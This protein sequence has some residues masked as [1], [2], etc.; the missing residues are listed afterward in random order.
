MH[1]VS[2][3]VPGM[4]SRRT[5]MK[6]TAAA[7]ALAPLGVGTASAADP[8]T[9]TAVREL[10]H[11]IPNGKVTDGTDTAS[12]YSIGGLVVRGSDAYFNKFNDYGWT[13]FHHIAGFHTPEPVFTVRT[14]RLKGDVETSPADLG[15]VNGLSYF[16]TE[17][18]DPD[19]V[20]SFY[21]P[22]LKAIGD[23]QV[24]QVNLNGEVTALFKAR[25]GSSHKKIA[26]VTYRGNGTWIVGTAGETKEEA[27]RFLRPYY[28]AKIVGDIFELDDFFQVPTV[29]T[30]NLGQDIYYH[31]PDDELLIP[32]WD[33]KSQGEPPTGLKNRIVVAE[34]GTITDGRIYSPKRWID[35][36]VPASAASKFE[37]EG[38]TR[39]SDGALFVASNIKAPD[40]REIDGI[41]KL[42]GK[43]S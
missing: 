6:S 5:V 7:L 31:A 27:D 4:M 22:M 16:A 14:V 21:I 26:S 11:R 17:G 19:E 10:I 33:G 43:K 41:H 30:Y 24:A 42:T 34:L 35:L 12:T 20:G 29:K 37:F 40:G 1:D 38:V 28:T 9:T 3:G 18:A 36:S 39:G 2:S 32:L 25:R 13:T 15:H 23:D 8:H